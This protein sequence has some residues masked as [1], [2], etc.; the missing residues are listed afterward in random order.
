MYIYIY[1][2]GCVYTYIYIYIYSITCVTHCWQRLD[3]RHYMT[4]QR[5]DLRHDFAAQALPKLYNT[6]RAVYGYHVRALTKRDEMRLMF[7]K[8]TRGA[9]R[10]APSV[11]TWVQTLTNMKEW[12]VPDSTGLIKEWNRCA[13]KSDQLVGGKSMAVQLVMEKMPT[14]ILETVHNHVSRY[15][16]TNCMFNDDTLSTKK[17]YPGFTF[18]HHKS[19]WGS[20][21]AVTERSMG[22]TITFHLAEWELKPLVLRRKLSK[23]EIEDNSEIAALVESMYQ[24]VVATT[25]LKAQ[26]VDD[27]FCGAYRRATDS[28]LMLELASIYQEK[29]DR[30]VLE[31]VTILKAL[32]L[33]HTQA[34]N[35]NPS[36]IAMV[37]SLEEDSFG[38]LVK[39]IDHDVK[40]MAVYLNKV[41]SYES[42]KYWAK[43]E[44][45]RRLHSH[46]HMGAMTFVKK[47]SK[48][49][50][51][52]STDAVLKGF[53][54]H[55]R[56]I[57]NKPHH[58]MGTD[59]L[60]AR[61][62][63][64]YVSHL[65]IYIYI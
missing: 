44:S 16:W 22:H 21:L 62:F 46:F 55:K 18:K 12:G 1:V 40:A 48:L 8:S 63:L 26:V 3:L 4:W 30:V 7:K 41:A 49:V 60:A 51:A 56:D 64:V 58:K 9:I 19:G 36:T 38:I 17:I 61:F 57:I 20:R 10:Q 47:H 15:G 28:H 32:L 53:L 11:I 34:H 29:P 52:S 13:A 14:S 25:P 23:K 65:Y 24:D 37:A 59:N 5:L 6:A 50:V 33:Q 42:A 54:E 2:Y 27:E 35:H 31:R 43:L 45:D 39:S